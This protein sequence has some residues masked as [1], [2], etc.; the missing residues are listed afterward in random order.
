MADDGAGALDRSPICNDMGVRAGHLAD[1]CGEPLL[2]R[3]DQGPIVG[4]GGSVEQP[5]AVTSAD[6]IAKASECGR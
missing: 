1:G 2:K 5:R 4:I 3:D 6:A